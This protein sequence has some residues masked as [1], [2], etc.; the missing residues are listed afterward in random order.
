MR[1]VLDSNVIIAALA[2][3][4]LCEA[5]FEYCL[6]T[7]ELF[8]CVDMQEEV[9]RKLIDKIRVPERIAHEISAYLRLNMTLVTPAAIE[10]EACRDKKDLMVLGTAASAR[11]H[12]IITGDIDLLTLKRYR[13]VKIVDPRSFWNIA[14]KAGAEGR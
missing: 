2:A 6:E 3:R 5:L 11:A 10:P 4:G 13:D 14:K 8:I 1:L 9:R 7:H 12:Y